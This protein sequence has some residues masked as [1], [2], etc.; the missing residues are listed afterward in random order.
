MDRA[1]ESAVA[2]T[3]IKALRQE[4]YLRYL[5]S[6]F[7]SSTKMDLR[8][9]SVDSGFLFDQDRVKEALDRAEKTVS[10]TFQQAVAKALAKPR[11]STGTPLVERGSRP[12]SGPSSSRQP[13]FGDSH[14]SLGSSRH[15]RARQFRKKTTDPPPPSTSKGRGRF[16]RR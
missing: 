11:P 16:F 2:L 5:P 6:S 3:N 9:S 7:T 15:D 12:V 13:R 1:Q 14:H 10:L 4:S 8:K